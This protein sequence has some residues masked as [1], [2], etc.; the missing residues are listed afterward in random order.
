MSGLV[1]KICLLGNFAVGKTSLC[2]RFVNNV[3]K[4]DYQTTVGVNIVTKQLM[5]DGQA[6]KLVIWDIAG[7]LASPELLSGYLAGS[8][9]CLLV[10]DGTRAETLQATEDLH[11][12]LQRDNPAVSTCC[13]IN[14][15]DLEQRW[16]VPPEW[17]IKQREK[18]WEVQ[19][20]S[21]LSGAGVEA[22]FA[23]LARRMLACTAERD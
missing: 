13:L 15:A 3:F 19:R 7:E 22:G 21:A 14:K 1:R 12:Y 8:H 11:A 9:G 16:E 4:H 20:S 17:L 23:S 5:V 6:L 10:A 18:G 2:Q